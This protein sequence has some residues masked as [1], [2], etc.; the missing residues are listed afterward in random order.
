MDGVCR[1]IFT[2]MQCVGAKNLSVGGKLGRDK[3]F[4]KRKN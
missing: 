3:D 1:A 2:K 4:A